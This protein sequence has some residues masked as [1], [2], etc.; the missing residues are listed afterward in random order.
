MDDAIKTYKVFVYG[1]LKSDGVN[2]K[3]YLQDT[4]SK[5][6]EDNFNLPNTTLKFDDTLPR[7]TMIPNPDSY[8]VGEIWEVTEETLHLLHQLEMVDICLYYFIKHPT[9][10]VYFYSYNYD[11]YEDVAADARDNHR[12]LVDKLNYETIWNNQLGKVQARLVI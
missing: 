7:L 3:P 1:T 10:D 11:E 2:N 4:N 8:V 12:R 6:V 9:V 5:L